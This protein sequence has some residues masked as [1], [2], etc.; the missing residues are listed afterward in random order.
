LEERFA[1]DLGD[2]LRPFIAAAVR[3]DEEE[4]AR[5]RTE[6]EDR[7]RT[8]EALAK[9][10][11]RVAW[12]TGIGLIVAPILVT[13]VERQKGVAEHTLGVATEAATAFVYQ[14]AQ[15]FEG[16]NGAPTWLIKSVLDRTLDLQAKLIGEG[17]TSPNLSRNEA[18]AL[19]KM[20]DVLL[21]LGDSTNAMSQAQW[22]VYYCRT[23]LTGQ[24]DK[25]RLPGVAFGR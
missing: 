23:L 10:R 5:V 18:A 17:Q 4:R 6:Q 21:R 1:E 16:V 8:A 3:H 14:V 22:A 25:L 9:A 2:T 12:A 11:G 24:P 15:G 7:V 20:S 19:I 13:A